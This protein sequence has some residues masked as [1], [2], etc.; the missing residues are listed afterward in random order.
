MIFTE[1]VKRSLSSPISS[2]LPCGKYLKTDRATFRPLRNE[3]NVAQTA[4]RKLAQNP[5]EAELDNLQDENLQAWKQLGASLKKTFE[6]E[7]RDIELIGWMLAVQLIVDNSIDGASNLI[8][9]LNELVENDWDTLNPVLPQDKLKGE[10]DEAQKAQF[11]AKVKAFF[12]I[13]GDSEDSSLLY[14]PLLMLPL[15]GNI[16]FFQYQSAENKGGAP[17]LR[18]QAT[19]ALV[20]QKSLVQARTDNLAQLSKLFVSVSE[21]VN[22]HTQ[23]MLVKGVNF[24]FALSLISKAQSAITYLTGLTPTKEHSE[25]SN[26]QNS[27]SQDNAQSMEIQAGVNDRQSVSQQSVSQVSVSVSETASFSEAAKM[28]N[29]NRDQAF[30]Q[31]RELAEYFRVSEPHSPVSFLLEKAI[32]WGYMPLPELM[33]ELLV[34][35]ENDQDKIFNLIGLDSEERVVL[36][37]VTSVKTSRPSSP[38]MQNSVQENA[39]HNTDQKETPKESSSKSSSGSTGLRW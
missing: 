9:W 3:F 38:P 17:Q 4:L 5:D 29:M 18:Q 37:E 11:E 7:S 6:T 27:S 35:R 1:D 36:P 16:T 26:S 30:V 34:G 39:S 31:L 2:E 10:G 32:R 20:S 23:P 25:P 33:T 12:Q 14:A 13:C 19:Q 21:C 28:N 22:K 15:V 24:T 8:A